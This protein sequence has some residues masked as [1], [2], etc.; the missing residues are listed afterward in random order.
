MAALTPADVVRESWRRIREY[1][2][3]PVWIHL[4]PEEESIARAE[5]LGS[6]GKFG[7]D[8]PLYGI[9]FAI[10]DNID[11][12]GAPTTAGCPDYAYLPNEP[13][14]CRLAPDRRRCDPDRQD[15]PRSV[16]HRTGRRPVALWRLFQRVRRSLHLWRIQFGIRG[17]GGPRTG[18][19]FARHRHRGFRTRASR[20]QCSRRAEAHARGDQHQRRG[21]GLPYARLRLLIHHELRGRRDCLCGGRRL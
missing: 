2:E 3:R 9:P 13:A 4:I 11:L 16:R 18:L 5:A 21:P 17:C 8:L 19:V 20:L 1:G 15:Q 6:F 12:A 10:K 7:N 14:H